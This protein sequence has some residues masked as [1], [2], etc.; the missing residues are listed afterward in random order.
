MEL[1]AYTLVYSD[2]LPSGRPSVRHPVLLPGHD[3]AGAHAATA[4]RMSHAKDVEPSVAERPQSPISPDDL[5]GCIFEM[6]R[7]DVLGPE[8]VDGHIQGH[9]I[10]KFLGRKDFEL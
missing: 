6:L 4:Q 9:A 5:Q 10:L 7:R 3:L 2:R 8:L 1:W